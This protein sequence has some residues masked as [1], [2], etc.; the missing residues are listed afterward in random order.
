M[1]K[2]STRLNSYRF[3]DFTVQ[4]Y[5]DEATTRRLFEYILENRIMGRT[6]PP[7]K[8]YAGMVKKL[9]WE[10]K[11]TFEGKRYVI[12]GGGKNL[13]IFENIPVKDQIEAKQADDRFNDP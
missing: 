2:S 12:Q 8:G 11:F 4:S 6:A 10:K 5:F 13:G 7:R 1:S 3:D 9:L